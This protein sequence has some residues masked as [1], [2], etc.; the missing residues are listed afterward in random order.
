MGPTL[1]A[2]SSAAHD[3]AGSRSATQ[4]IGNARHRRARFARFRSSCPAEGEEKA[5][6]F[7]ISFVGELRLSAAIVRLHSSKKWPLAS[8]DKNNCARKSHGIRTHISLSLVLVL[9]VFRPHAQ[10]SINYIPQSITRPLWPSG[11]IPFPSS[12]HYTLPER[13]AHITRPCKFPPQCHH[14]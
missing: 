2:I 1:H 6:T 13:T 14:L 12:Q 4:H 5:G 8:G 7:C 9:P 11:I 3:D 10:R